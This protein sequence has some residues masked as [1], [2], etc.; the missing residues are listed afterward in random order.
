MDLTFRRWKVGVHRRDDVV[1]GAYPIGW[2]HQVVQ[3]GPVTPD[4]FPRNFR[5]RLQYPTVDPL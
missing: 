3:V 1:G 2:Y 5:W 4:F